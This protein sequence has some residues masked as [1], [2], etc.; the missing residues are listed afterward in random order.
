MIFFL[1]SINKSVS[2]IIFRSLRNV[3]FQ[4]LLSF[5]L[6]SITDSNCCCPS[7]WTPDENRSSA[8]FRCPLHRRPVPPPTFYQSVP[9]KE[10]SLLPG[11]CLSSKLSKLT[12]S[13]PS[14]LLLHNNSHYEFSSYPLAEFN[15]AQTISLALALVDRT[16]HIHFNL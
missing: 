15:K 10:C 3:I 2:Q 8:I 5:T 7:M 9:N 1:W 16:I 12:Q 13:T 6:S 14:K 4:P 11:I